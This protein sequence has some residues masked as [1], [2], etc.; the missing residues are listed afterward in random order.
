MR[1]QKEFWIIRMKTLNK[2]SYGSAWRA[3]RRRNR[4]T[5]TT[6]TPFLRAILI[7]SRSRLRSS[8]LVTKYCVFPLIAA[9]R[10]SSS[11]GS[12]QIFNS[13]VVGTA[14][15]RAAMSRT[16]N[17]ASRCGYLNRRI[18]RGRLRTSASSPSCVSEVTALNLSRR[19]AATTCP[20]GPEGFRK[21]DIQTFVSSRTTSGTAFCL[22]L[23]SGSSDFR[24]DIALRNV[25]CPGLHSAQQA[26][27]VALPSPLWMKRHDQRGFLF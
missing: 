17:S 23:G 18:N 9:S 22:H 25:F 12:R 5:E 20:G 21:A 14:V 6:R 7:K 8:S 4:L 1:Q 13:P 24:L 11:S 27:Q 16:N 26:I 19:Q 2:N 10:I 15:A 3:S